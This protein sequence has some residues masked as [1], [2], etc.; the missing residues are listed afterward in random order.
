MI[1]STPDIDRKH[2]QFRFEKKCPSSEVNSLC[3]SIYLKEA[4][5]EAITK[6]E[7]EINLS[8]DKKNKDK[9]ISESI[10]DLGKLYK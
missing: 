2:K 10:N 3:L 6:A 4:I 8:K 7:V 9:L 5:N 1:I